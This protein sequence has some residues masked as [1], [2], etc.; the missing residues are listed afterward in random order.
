MATSQGI[1]A[2][3]LQGLYGV[4]F[5]VRESV[6]AVG[7]T[8]VSAARNVPDRISLLITNTG[9]TAITLSTRPG[10]VSGKG[11][12]L[13]DNGSVYSTN[14]RDDGIIPAWLHFAIGAAPAGELYVVE[15][16]GDS[17]P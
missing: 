2:K 5:R 16:I 14:V 15:I 6:V 12:L 9:T 13:L 7:V 4:N 10:I 1:A 17:L 11:I 3:F 8:P